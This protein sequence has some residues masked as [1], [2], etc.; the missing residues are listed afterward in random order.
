VKKSSLLS[1]PYSFDTFFDE[2]KEKDEEIIWSVRAFSVRIPSVR[3]FTRMYMVITSKTLYCIYRHWFR[4]KIRQLARSDI[5]QLKCYPGRLLAKCL[6]KTS[7]ETWLVQLY[8]PLSKTLPDN[9]ELGNE[10]G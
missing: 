6:I 10:T 3:R 1:L 9:L 4:F 5:R 7:G 8:Q 2:K